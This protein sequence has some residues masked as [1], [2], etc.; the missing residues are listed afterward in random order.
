LV[1]FWVATA[2]YICFGLV[3][4]LVGPW[5]LAPFVSHEPT[6]FGQMRFLKACELAIGAAFWMLRHRLHHDPFAQRFVAFV[7][8][9]TPV[10]RIVGMAA[11]GV[12]IP[13]FQVIAFMEV[14]GALVFTAWVFETRRAATA[15]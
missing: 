7:L 3:G 14:V 15:S 5:E 11:D 6:A 13:L 10:A 9:V 4:V 12:P 1:V 2:A 8:I